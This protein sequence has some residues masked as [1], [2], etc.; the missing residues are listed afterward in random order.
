MANGGVVEYTR[1]ETFTYFQSKT[2]YY[3]WVMNWINSTETDQELSLCAPPYND[4]NNPFCYDL[5][6]YFDKNEDAPMILRC[7]IGLIPFYCPFDLPV[8]NYRVNQTFEGY[9]QDEEEDVPY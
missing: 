7:Y 5:E 9:R 3:D 8:E 6:T 4:F 1:K 2:D